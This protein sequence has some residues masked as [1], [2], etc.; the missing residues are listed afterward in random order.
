MTIVVISVR[1]DETRYKLAEQ[2]IK[3]YGCPREPPDLEF[4]AKFPRL[5]IEKDTENPMDQP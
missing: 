4:A 5:K 2:R 1:N 3:P